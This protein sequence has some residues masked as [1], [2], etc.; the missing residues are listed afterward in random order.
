QQKRFLELIYRSALR[1]QK[2]VQSLLSF[3]RRHPPERKLSDVNTLID[4]TVEFMQYQLRTSNIEIVTRL[5][6]SLPEVMLD[7]H[8]MQQVFLNII[9]N[10][11]QAI[12]S[13]G[14]KGRIAITTECLPP[15]LRIAFE[16]D[17]PGI[18]EENLPRLFDPFFTT[19]E[20]G[21]GTGL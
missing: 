6:R 15:R 19:K 18:P 9:N 1:C 2:I 20:I 10:A 13:K 14:A 17:G 4:N 8:Q 11:R 5:D 16:D 3:A 7:P 12:E 21:K